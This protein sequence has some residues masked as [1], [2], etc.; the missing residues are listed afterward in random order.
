MRYVWVAVGPTGI[1]DG[2]YWFRSRND[3][4]VFCNSR[5]IVYPHLA[6]LKPR[7]V[8]LYHH[9]HDSYSG[10]IRV[11]RNPLTSLIISTAR[12]L[13]DDIH[14]SNEDWLLTKKPLLMYD[15]TR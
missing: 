3:A 14:W 4:T 6:T 9:T 5:S 13:Y 10:T 15:H 8:D 11:I 1:I 7:R 12:A 2:H